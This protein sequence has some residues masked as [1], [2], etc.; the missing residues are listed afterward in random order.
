MNVAGNSAI[1]VDSGA[2]QDRGYQIDSLLTGSGT[3]WWHEWSGA[4]GGVD[5]QIT[6]STNTFSGQW[7]VDQGVL[8]GV[9]TNSLGMNN[10]IV[11]TNGLTAAVETLYNI[12]NPNASLILGANGKMF[13]HQTNSFASV[14][15]N[16]TVLPVGTY[17]AG[18]LSSTYPANFPAT[19]TQQAG[20]TFTA[21]SGE[22]IVLGGGPPKSPRITGFHV[23]GTTLSLSATN[24]T[25]GGLW[26]LLQ[27]TNVALPLNQW[28]TNL[29][30]NFDGSGDLSTNLA[31]PAT[32]PQEFYLLK[33]Q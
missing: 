13:L 15:V 8:V 7:I 11:G 16:G 4:L 10:L 14:T 25:A 2:A 20:S 9:G 28:Q 33:V 19:W 6:C 31:S 32:N 3:L 22:I 30:G 21:A 27:S 29:T 26:L 18:T 24:G 5:L 23:S 17:T 12:Y 1:Y